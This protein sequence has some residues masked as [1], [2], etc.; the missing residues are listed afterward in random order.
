VSWAKIDDLLPHHQKLVQ[1]GALAPA[2]YGYYV[3]SINFC[4][5]HFTDGRV[6]R[7][8]FPLI[9]PSCPRPTRTLLSAL[10]RV[11]LWEREAEGVWYVHDFLDHNDPAKVIKAKLR[12]DS[13]RKRRTPPSGIPPESERRP[14]T[15]PP[16][17][18]PESE[19]IPDVASDKNQIR[20]EPEPDKS[21]VADPPPGTSEGFSIPP[22]RKEPDRPVRIGELLTRFRQAPDG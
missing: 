9:L 20:K 8:D 22:E 13:D 18:Q 11:H 15:L 19:R 4:R 12:A 14:R 1:T 3:A 2:V 17:F 16:G 21:R 6:T 7:A 5:R 10:E